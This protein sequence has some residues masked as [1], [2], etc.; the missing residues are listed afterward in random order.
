MVS[1][2]GKILGSFVPNY[3]K[4]MDDEAIKTEIFNKGIVTTATCNGTYAMLKTVVGNP[5]TSESIIEAITAASDVNG[6]QTN[7]ND[8]VNT[9]TSTDDPNEEGSDAT[10]EKLESPNTASPMTWAAVIVSL[11]L[12]GVAV[13]SYLSKVKPELF[14]K[15]K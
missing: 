5:P 8:D 1:P 15:N 3:S 10:V 7:T 13:Y 2:D 6:Q 11:I 9:D 14:K 4:V 12:V